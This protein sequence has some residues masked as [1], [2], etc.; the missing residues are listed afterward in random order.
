MGELINFRDYRAKTEKEL[1]EFLTETN[2][3]AQINGRILEEELA[4]LNPIDHDYYHCL[5]FLLEKLE[6]WEAMSIENSTDRKN[7][8]RQSFSR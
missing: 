2:K 4:D 8:K 3:L 7:T 1:Q 5:L 6:Q